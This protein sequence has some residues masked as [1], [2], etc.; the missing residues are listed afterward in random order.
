MSNLSFRTP[1]SQTVMFDFQPISEA[2]KH[3]QIRWVHD[4]Y[5]T[6]NPVFD[7]L[8]SALQ[9]ADKDGALSCALVLTVQNRVAEWESPQTEAFLSA[10]LP[11]ERRVCDGLVDFF[12]EGVQWALASSRHYISKH[13]YVGKGNFLYCSTT[14]GTNVQIIACYDEG[15]GETCQLVSSPVGNSLG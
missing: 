11:S 1:L 3:D 7:L 2:F 14:R 5:K 10:L 13:A 8:L 15:Y 6:M 12:V 4:F 9:V